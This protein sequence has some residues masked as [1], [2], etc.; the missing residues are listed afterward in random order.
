MLDYI[1]PWNKLT[2]FSKISRFKT[3]LNLVPF[4]SPLM[5]TMKLGFVYAVCVWQNLVLS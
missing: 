4:S 2:D 5:T 1:Y 3:G